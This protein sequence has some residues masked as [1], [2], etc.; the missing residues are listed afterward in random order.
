MKSR[1]GGVLIHNYVDTQQHPAKGHARFST[2]ILC[3]EDK[4][5]KKNWHKKWFQSHL[6]FQKET[7]LSDLM[8]QYTRAW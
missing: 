7:L 6:G 8:P 3:Y 4:K 5:K 1:L 2:A